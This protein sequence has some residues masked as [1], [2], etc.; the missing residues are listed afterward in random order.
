M[1]VAIVG[2]TGLLGRHLA[3]NL[4]AR[5][6]VPVV[7]ARRAGVGPGE[8][9][10]ADVEDQA[11]LE[12]ALSGCE[13]VVSCFGSTQQVGS[14]TY[15][16]VH[17]RG[18]SRVI[19]AAKAQRIRRIVHVSA[20]SASRTS[21][22]AWA[23]AKWAGEELVARCLLD[24]TVLRPAILFGPGDGFVVPLAALLRRLPFAPLPGEGQ[25][26]LQPTAAGD[27][28]QAVT[29]CLG[30]PDTVGEHLDLA[31]PEVLTLSDIYDRVLEAASLRRPRLRVPYAFIEPASHL[32]RVMPGVEFSFDQLAIVEEER[33]GDPL[34]T[35]TRLDLKLSRFTV[36]A[37]RHAL[38][39]RD[40]A[41]AAS[42]C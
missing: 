11:A 1:R 19:A 38:Q 5:G 37:I 26:L 17:V 9:R 6:D 28:A 8:F 16:D 4:A 34:P 12:A 24:V 33:P 3:A 36:Q 15:R 20:L 30:R 13:A 32:W 40:P 42:L 10:P 7:I 22:S 39:S 2:G 35:A 41:P 21:K 23:R 14:V 25:A 29:A 18:L 27:V 31:G